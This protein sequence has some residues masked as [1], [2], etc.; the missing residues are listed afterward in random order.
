MICA[1]QTLYIGAIFPI[2]LTNLKFILACGNSFL[3]LCCN[4]VIKICA[5]LWRSG[6][7]CKRK[8]STLGFWKARV[9]PILVSSRKRLEGLQAPL[10]PVMSEFC[11]VSDTV[12][13]TLVPFCSVESQNCMLVQEKISLP[14]GLS[15]ASCCWGGEKYP[16]P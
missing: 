15:P 8:S 6:Q 9:I 1:R 2:Q 5:E 3:K 4:S 12:A 16:S 13:L 7:H 11:L 10:H 14:Q